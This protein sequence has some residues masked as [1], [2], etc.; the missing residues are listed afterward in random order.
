MTSKDDALGLE[1]RPELQEV[2]DLAIVDDHA[3]TIR[4]LHGLTSSLGEVDHLE[5]SMPQ[6]AAAISV[7]PHPFPIGTPVGQGRHHGSNDGP[8]VLGVPQRGSDVKNSR[9]ATH[10]G[11]LI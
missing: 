11:M 10:R 7:A 6:D 4:G 2:I 8:P 1:E 9:Y 5:A 3:R